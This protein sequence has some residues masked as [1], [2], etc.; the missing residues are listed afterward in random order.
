MT[1]GWTTSRVADRISL[2]IWLKALKKFSRRVL[3]EVDWYACYGLTIIESDLLSTETT[4]MKIAGCYKAR[5]GG[6]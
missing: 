6:L 4:I 2:R 3:F 5:P 1:R